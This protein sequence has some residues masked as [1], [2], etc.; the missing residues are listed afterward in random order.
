[1]LK[2]PKA[3]TVRRTPSAETTFIVICNGG[4]AMTTQQIT[5]D[6]FGSE[7]SPIKEKVFRR[8]R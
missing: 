5:L 6:K 1:M 7:T 3:Y 4:V 2:C 8:R